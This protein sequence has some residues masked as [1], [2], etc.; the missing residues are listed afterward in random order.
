MRGR[1]SYAEPLE[2]Y[3][4]ARSRGMDFVTISDHNTL[5]LSLIHI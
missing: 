1:E 4:A 3:A 5:N 2:V